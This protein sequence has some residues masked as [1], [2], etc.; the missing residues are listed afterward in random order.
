MNKVYEIKGATQFLTIYD[1]AVSIKPK[2][3]F[4]FLTKGMAGERFIYYKE[5]SSIQFRASTKLLS[6]Y[7]EFYF[8]G[9]NVS[10]QGGGLFSGTSN[11]NR[12]YFYNKQL[13]EMLEAKKYI[14]SKL[15]SENN[16]QSEIS[17][18]DVLVKYKKLLEA[19]A[20][21]QEEYDKKK[22]QLLGL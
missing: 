10:K 17:S 2:G 15:G 7:I 6:G 16:Q 20:I 13:N 5:L 1:T 21:T 14:E 9:H 18:A 22:K 12:F 11:E 4:G 3:A 19:E 8:A